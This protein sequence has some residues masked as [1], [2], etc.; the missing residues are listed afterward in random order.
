[1]LQRAPP[2]PHRGGPAAALKAGPHGALRR[3]SA[4]V[5]IAWLCEGPP[6]RSRTL[7]AGVAPIVYIQPNTLPYNII[8]AP[9]SS[10][11]GQEPPALV[12]F[13]D[14]LR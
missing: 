4:G 3:S 8:L 1:M 14:G 12:G 13:Y 7:G 6:W 9:A 10:A 5:A 11:G 2:T